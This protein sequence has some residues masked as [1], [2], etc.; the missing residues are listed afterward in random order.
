[1][2]FSDWAKIYNETHKSPEFKRFITRRK[3]YGL[4]VE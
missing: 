2:K 1:M 3:A 4:D